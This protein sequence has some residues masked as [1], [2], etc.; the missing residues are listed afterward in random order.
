[1]GNEEKSFYNQNFII[2]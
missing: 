2:R 1:L